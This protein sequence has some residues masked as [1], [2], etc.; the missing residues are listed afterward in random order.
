M[1]RPTWPPLT[2][3]LVILDTFNTL[4]NLA[5]RKLSASSGPLRWRGG[6]S[7]PGQP[8]EFPVRTVNEAS[9]TLPD[10]AD[11]LILTLTDYWTI[12]SDLQYPD[13]TSRC[14]P[15]ALIHCT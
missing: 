6:I 3:R 1:F 13:G 11:H 2:A 12:K 4:H 14:D 8:K 10:Y 9:W 7:L 15:P 5:G